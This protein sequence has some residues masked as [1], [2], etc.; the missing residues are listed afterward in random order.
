MDAAASM[1]GGRLQGEELQ[2]NWPDEG[3][4]RI[5]DWRIDLGNPSTG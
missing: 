4:G 1:I 2:W 5:G 3:C